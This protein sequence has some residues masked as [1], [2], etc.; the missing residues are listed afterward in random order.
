MPDQPEAVLPIKRLKTV[1]ERIVAQCR[2]EDVET[3]EAFNES[4]EFITLYQSTP[5]ALEAVLT[6]LLAGAAQNP[7]ALEHMCLDL[8][9]GLDE[10]RWKDF[11]GTEGECDPR[12]DFREHA[13]WSMWRVQGVDEPEP[14]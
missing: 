12:G 1:I 9:N 10:L 11:F 14:N 4:F 6:A 8:D 3:V 7:E 13:D 2:K 5:E